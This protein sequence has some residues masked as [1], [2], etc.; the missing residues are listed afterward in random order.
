VPLDVVAAERIAGA[1]SRLHV[2]GI[3]DAETSESSPHE[4]LRNGMERDLPVV[5]RF[6]SEAA[7]V[8]RYRVAHARVRG[9]RERLHDKNDPVRAAVGRDD[10]PSSRT[11][12]VNTVERYS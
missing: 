7:A 8:D 9:R 2:H 12:P 1:H 6:R 4:R 3:S 11:I 10:A 5:D